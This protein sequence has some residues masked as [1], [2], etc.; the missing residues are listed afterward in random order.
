[1]IRGRGG[2][3]IT[4]VY[5]FAI[6]F[7]VAAAIVYMVV[8]FYGKP[9]DIRETEA[10]LLTNRVASCFSQGGY[11]A[12]E[13][14]QDSFKEN[15]LNICDLNLE[16]EDT[17]DWNSL[18][19]YYI[20]VSLNDFATGEEISNFYEGNLNLKD[21]C[22]QKGNN[23]PACIERSFYSIDRNN[24]QYKIKIISAVRKTE[25]NVQ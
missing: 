24:N 18:G 25:K 3:K 9:Y 5:W 17:Y 19:Q 16:T 12:P 10:N 1:M 21:S 2:E 7:I 15:F 4:S 8:A 22:S 11:L 14:L 6:L 13:V 20:E 23:L